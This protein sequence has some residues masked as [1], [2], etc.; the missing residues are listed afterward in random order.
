[1]TF[2][3]PLVL[4]LDTPDIYVGQARAAR[5]EVDLFGVAGILFCLLSGQRPFRSS[6]L[7]FRQRKVEECF[8]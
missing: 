2:A 7:Q 4:A 3:A 1:M 8:E 6:D 5:F